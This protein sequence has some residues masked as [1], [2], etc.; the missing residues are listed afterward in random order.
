MTK[1]QKLS[2]FILGLEGQLADEI[3]ALR[4]TLLADALICAKAKL[5]S[6]A[7]GKR[8]RTFSPSNQGPFRPHKIVYPICVDGRPLLNTAPEHR[9]RTFV[10]APCP[11]S[12]APKPPVQPAKVNAIPTA[13]T[14]RGMQCFDCL[15]WGH[16]RADCPNKVQQRGRPRATLPSQEKAFA[17]WQG[18]P[19]PRKTPRPN[20]SVNVNYV[21]VSKE[22]AE[23]AKV[24]AALDPSGRNCQY[25]IL[26]VEGDYEGKPLT[27]LVN[28]SSSHS[29]IS[30]NLAKR[31]NVE[32]RPIGKKLRVALANESMILSDENVVDLAFQL[33]E[34][35]T[36]QCFRIMKMGKF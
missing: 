17:N 25:T 6:F 20:Q 34:K 21:D 7:S 12:L 4:P 8:K 15:Q 1:E 26:E 10:T 23:Q 3:N 16:H 33:A 27:F 35:P 2:R 11:N 32:P 31:L 5:A 24:Y 13:Q 19:S 29:F 9:T 36:N 18:S 28:S 22:A 30:P 14:G